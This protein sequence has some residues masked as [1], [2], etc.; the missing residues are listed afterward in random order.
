[1]EK[2]KHC[3]FFFHLYICF[4]VWQMVWSV[5]LTLFLCSCY[6]CIL[7][8][9]YKTKNACT[10]VH[11]QM[12]VLYSF[13]EIFYISEYKAMFIQLLIYHIYIYTDKNTVKVPLFFSVFILSFILLNSYILLFFPFLKVLVFVSIKPFDY[14]E[15]W[16]AFWWPFSIATPWQWKATAWKRALSAAERCEV[17]EGSS[18]DGCWQKNISVKRIN[19]AFLKSPQSVCTNGPGT[20]WPAGAVKLD[21]R[22]VFPA[23]GLSLKHWPC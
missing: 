3:F 6:Y 11:L 19:N 1:M 20:L 13:N 5:C 9:V 23:R 10:L 18:A 14:N 21:L 2:W 15:S 8:Y 4:M 7:S 16:S 22:R 12:Y 17:A